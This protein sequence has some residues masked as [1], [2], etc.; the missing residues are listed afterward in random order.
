MIEVEALD[1]NGCIS[2]PPAPFG[3][4]RGITA[5]DC[6]LGGGFLFFFRGRGGQLEW[7]WGCG[8]R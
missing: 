5:G 6:D 2:P 1:R 3:E 7:R 8:M 4:E